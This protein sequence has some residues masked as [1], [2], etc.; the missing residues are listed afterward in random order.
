MESIERIDDGEMHKNITVIVPTLAPSQELE[1]LL[2]QLRAF[3]FDF[4]VVQARDAGV[5]ST[6]QD[7]ISAL[8][9]RCRCRSDAAALP[10][11]GHHVNTAGGA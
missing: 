1:A 7:G 8:A 10:P 5:E 11:D 4:I 3:R 6:R 2:G 9:R